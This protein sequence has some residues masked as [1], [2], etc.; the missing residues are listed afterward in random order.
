M[1]LSNLAKK[2]TLIYCTPNI[3]V[4]TIQAESFFL[5]SNKYNNWLKWY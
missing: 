2:V 5:I 1:L 3:L 4:S